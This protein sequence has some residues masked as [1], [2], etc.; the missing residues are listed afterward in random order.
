[1]TYKINTSLTFITKLNIQ[2]GMNLQLS[3]CKNLKY[4]TSV[5]SF[6]I[7]NSNFIVLI[8]NLCDFWDEG[9]YLT[10]TTSFIP[11]SMPV[12]SLLIY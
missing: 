9:L 11:T 7:D 6:F 3:F 1:M 8:Q 4:C 2:V 10:Y 12:S 5:T